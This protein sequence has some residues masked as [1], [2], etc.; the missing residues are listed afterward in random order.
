MLHVPPLPGSPRAKQGMTKI[1]EHVLADAQTLIQ[2]GFDGLMVENFGD[3]PFYPQ[4]VPAVT[5][6]AL[7]AVGGLI[8]TRDLDA[9]PYTIAYR[10]VPVFIEFQARW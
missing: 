7:T 1:I 9:T 8:P 2:A 4:R 10:G 3:A 5:V 6:A